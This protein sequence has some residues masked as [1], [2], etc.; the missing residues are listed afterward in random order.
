[1]KNGKPW[2]THCVRPIVNLQRVWHGK[3]FTQYPSLHPHTKLSSC[4]ALLDVWTRAPNEN[5]KRLLLSSTWRFKRTHVIENKTAT[6]VM[7]ET[8]RPKHLTWHRKWKRDA[9]WRQQAM[10]ARE[11]DGKTEL[12]KNR[13]AQDTGSNNYC[14]MKPVLVKW[15]SKQLCVCV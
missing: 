8:R 2:Q 4:A 6:D 15:V 14:W 11:R 12:R 13:S 1:M 3:G 9:R 7:R 10:R 5:L